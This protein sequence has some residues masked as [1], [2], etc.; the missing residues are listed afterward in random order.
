MGEK[1][2]K[3]TRNKDELKNLTVEKKLRKA[4]IKLLRD[5][6]I[7]I[8]IA[9][10]G[11]VMISMNLNRFY[12][13]SYKNMQQQL[14]ICRDVQGVGKNVLWAITATQNQEEKINSAVEYAQ[15][16]EK[17]VLALEKSFSDQELNKALDT[18]LKELKA[19]RLEVIE[20]V[21]SGE[22]EKALELFNGDYDEATQM[23]QSVL[24]E[25][26]EVA[27][28]QAATAYS[29]ASGLV[30]I[31]I[32]VL[33]LVSVISFINFKRTQKT[34]TALMLEP[35]ME[36]QDTAKSLKMGELNTDIQY[37]SQDEFGNLADNFRDACAQMQT[38]ISD[39]GYLLAEMADGNF[40]IHTRAEEHYV[41][42]FVLLLQNIRKMNRGLNA[43]LEKIN[44]SAGQVMLGS[45][46]LAESAQ[47]LAE[48][49]TEQAGAVQQLLA[50]VEH[51]ADIAQDS[52][53]DSEKAAQS[54][55]DS[56]KVAGKSREEMNA[57]TEAMDRIN[58]TSGEIENIIGAIEDI[59][60]QT[61]LLSLNAS[62]EAARAG[63]AGKGFAVVAD[64]IG[65]LAQD[66]A[67]SAVS[68]RELIGRSMEE[69]EKG[70]RIVEDTMETISSV[71]VSME[72]FAKM[73]SDIAH[74]SQEQAAL[75]K[76]VEAGIQQI[77]SVVES[78]ST[79]AQETSA[80]SE[81]LSLQAGTLEQ[82][83][84]A[85]QLRKS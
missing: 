29:R 33:V 10:M 72:Q 12:K 75:V 85:F 30:V 63:E 69:V 73:A 67:Q 13:E 28:E 45:N 60:S 8:I 6:I 1:E 41:G 78:N 35:I 84:T 15:K 82:M 66:S 70:N 74:S 79:V 64:Q 34:L 80:I 21:Q 81:E 25:I 22:K 19:L 49:A 52:A 36:L 62:I 7:A 17:N 43:T 9:L 61:N 5:F 27:D 46:Q 77:S 26:G 53:K 2:K 11:I 83:I 40:D 76:Q 59:A 4:F 57:L 47:S 51:V 39:M 56:T 18:A 58:V 14:E 42:E 71:L 20:L 32:T 54:V 48:G 37:E 16:V 31:I 3:K 55:K 68:T 38:V 23:I 24:M 65:K 50:T 44:Q